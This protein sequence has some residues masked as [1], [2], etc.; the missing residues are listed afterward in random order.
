QTLR[1]SEYEKHKDRNPDRVDGT[2]QWFL[3]HPK[4]RHW[5]ESKA[6]SLLWVSADPGCGKSVLSK[7]LVDKELRS[8]KSRTTCYFFFK[9]DNEE[10]KSTTKALSALLHQL[11]S[12]KNALVKY[13]ITDFRCDGRK[14]PKLFDKLWS[15]LTKATVDPE[16]GEVI[17]VLDALDECEEL[18]RFKLIDTLNHF[19]RN[20]TSNRVDNATLKF[21][22]TSRPYFDIERGF[23]EL[24]SNFPTIRLAGEEES[25]SIKREINVVIRAKIQKIGTKLMLDDSERSSLERDFLNITHRTYLWVKLTFEVIE[26][27]LAITKKKLQGIVGTIPDTLDKAYEAIL[28]RS[29]DRE[30]A[31]KLLHIIVSATRPLSVREM[32]VALAI[33]ES[34]KSQ[35]NLDLEPEDRFRITVRNLC[36]L[37]VSVIDSRIYLIHQTA[38]EFLVTNNAATCAIPRIWKNSLEPRESNLVLAEICVLYLLFSEFEHGFQSTNSGHIFLDYSAQFWTSH[39]QKAKIKDHKSRIAKSALA[40]CDVSS[41]RCQL[42][43]NIHCGLP[44]LCSSLNLAAYLGHTLTVEQLLLGKGIDVDAKDNNGWTPLSSAANNG[45]KEIVELLL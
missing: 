5:Q 26:Q 25:E 21:L 16:A 7:S 10:Q 32:N 44:G 2:C 27:R 13:A 8:I 24:T 15:I 22:V 14:L 12:Q 28:E 9:D 40:L 11:F 38:K 6:S 34:S 1:T 29:T 33:D 23:R 30:L 19:Y 3:Q 17:C 42:W 36:G 35:E 41:K 31:R 18:G 20:D 37:F 43:Y 4:F 45:H 39:F